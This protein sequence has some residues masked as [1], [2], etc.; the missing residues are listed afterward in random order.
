M[1]GILTKRGRWDTYKD[2]KMKV[3]TWGVGQCQK[4]QKPGE[5]LDKRLPQDSGRSQPMH[6]DLPHSR[7]VGEQRPTLGNL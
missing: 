4:P 7:A 1:T 6:L 2:V 3:E 5:D